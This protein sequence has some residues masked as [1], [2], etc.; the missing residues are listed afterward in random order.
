MQ[1]G[2]DIDDGAGQSLKTIDKR[3]ALA[4][5]IKSQQDAGIEP[6][7]PPELLDGAFRK[8]FKDM[9]VEEFRGLLDTVKQIEHLGR[10]KQHLL[11]AKGRRECR[12]RAR[13]GDRGKHRAARGRP[14]RRHPHADH[15]HGPCAAGS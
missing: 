7:I 11:T 3:A 6:D 15:K 8:S 2:A 14:H 9:T 10:L 13:N 1:E 12:G 5:W 4:D